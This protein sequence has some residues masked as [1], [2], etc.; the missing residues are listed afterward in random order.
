MH[1]NFIVACANLIAFNVGIPQ[2]RD[3]KQIYQIAAS[4]Q[5]K[6]YTRKIL[7]IETPEEA[8]KREEANLPPPKEESDTHDDEEVIQRLAVEL[9]PFCS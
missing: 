4:Q 5:G 1:L 8:K 6:P 3:R 9:I 2:I 7:K